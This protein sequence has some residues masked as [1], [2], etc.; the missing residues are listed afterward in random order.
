M[1]LVVAALALSTAAAVGGNCKN[2]CLNARKPEYYADCQ[3][4]HCTAGGT[5]SEDCQDCFGDVYNVMLKHD[6]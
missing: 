2:V 6:H 5:C 3:T 4:E 1:R